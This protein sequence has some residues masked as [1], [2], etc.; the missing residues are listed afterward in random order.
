M[1]NPTCQGEQG[2]IPEQKT[3]TSDGVQLILRFPLFQ[4]SVRNCL[5]LALNSSEHLSKVDFST[6]RKITLSVS[7][8][9]ISLG[10]R[11]CVSICC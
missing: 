9:S 6:M 1:V 2:L 4:A 8:T 7:I 10:G 5:V 3:P 11:C